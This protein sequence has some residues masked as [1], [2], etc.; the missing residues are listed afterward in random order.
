MGLKQSNYSKWLRCAKA[1]SNSADN[2]KVDPKPALRP[3]R[4]ILV[5]DDNPIIQRT[6]Y[7]ALRDKGYRVLIAENVANAL[8][9][10]RRESPELILLDINFTP[11]GGM[12]DGATRDGFWA[13][14]WMRRI[15]ELQDIPV[16]MISS[17][18]ADTFRPKALAAGAKAYFQKPLDKEVLVAAIGSLLA[19]KPFINPKPAA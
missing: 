15:D 2:R 1:K 8:M 9:I 6:L 5:A 12:E 16:V 13:M 4:K 11:D 7:F 17:N 19:G 3:F 14:D 18:E 10:V